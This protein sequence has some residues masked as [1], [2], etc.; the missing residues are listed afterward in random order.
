M[1]IPTWSYPGPL[2][3][4]TPDPSTWDYGQG[5]PPDN[6]APSDGPWLDTTTGTLYIPQTEAP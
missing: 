3:A 6:R 1:I 2:P 5:P 4:H